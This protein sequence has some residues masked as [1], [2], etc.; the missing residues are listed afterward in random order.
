MRTRRKVKRKRL[1]EPD[2]FIT[3]SEQI[4]L[5]ITKNWRSILWGGIAFL[6]VL[7]V[8][9]GIIYNKRR[10]DTKAFEE[11]YKAS[12]PFK[13]ED[14]GGNDNN[15]VKENDVKEKGDEIKE[16]T[17]EKAV[18]IYEDIIKRYPTTKAAG[19][20]NLYLGHIYY[21]KGLYDKAIEVYSKVKD[22]WGGILVE[23]A[24][25]GIGY[26]YEGLGKHKEAIDIYRKIIE[27]EGSKPK[28]EYYIYIGRCYEE[29]GDNEGAKR[30]YT[31][32][33]EKYPDSKEA[34]RIKDK[35]KE[36]GVGS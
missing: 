14:Q 21:E 33:I 32:F 18:E 15:D 26:S 34:E 31:E 36:L 4:V 35:I 6:L 27:G 17:K 13:S 29:I 11:L 3:T 30:V 25:E 19:Y 7:L 2:E 5:Y 12:V 28:E 23:E 10:I 9:I 8:S 20:A 24:L 22:R 16:K 1:N